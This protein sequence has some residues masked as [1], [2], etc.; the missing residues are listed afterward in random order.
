MLVSGGVTCYGICVEQLSHHACDGTLPYTANRLTGK[1]WTMLHCTQLLYMF[2]LNPW[3]Q[4]FHKK[5]GISQIF[6]T[7]LMTDQ[8]KCEK[9]DWRRALNIDP[10][11]VAM[12]NV[13]TKHPVEDFRI[14]FKAAWGGITKWR[15]TQ[16]PQ[17]DDI[18]RLTLQKL[19]QVA[20]S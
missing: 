10:K 7:Q 13:S 2:P 1:K 8:K 3:R 6:C 12:T 5:L 14:S 20:C 11:K 4:C 17:G 15:V 16:G 19:R 9:N 18:R